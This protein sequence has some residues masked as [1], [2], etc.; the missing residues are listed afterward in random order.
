MYFILNWHLTTFLLL[1][2]TLKLIMILQ[3]KHLSW[4]PKNLAFPFTRHSS[5][6][7]ALI[8]P[9]KRSFHYGTKEASL[10]LHNKNQ[11]KALKN[12][13]NCGNSTLQQ[14]KKPYCKQDK[15]GDEEE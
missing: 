6:P 12:L 5:H 15:E 9:A 13:N 1:D 7:L 10:S 3:G 8:F 4:F 14:I 11:D 2:I